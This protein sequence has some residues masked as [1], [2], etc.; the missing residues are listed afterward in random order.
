MSIGLSTIFCRNFSISKKSAILEI[1]CG[2]GYL[3][4]AVA[5]AGY[6]I[7]GLDISQEAVKNA[8][9][10]YGNHYLCADLAEYVQEHKKQFDVIIMT[11]LIEHTP[12]IKHFISIVNE[13]VK[14]D[15]HIVLTTPNKSAFAGDVVWQTELPPIHLWW[16]SK[17]SVRELAKQIGRKAIFT[18][19]SEFNKLNPLRPH[20]TLAGVPTVKT[21]FSADNKLLVIERIR[22][23]SW[24]SRNFKKIKIKFLGNF[25]KYTRVDRNIFCAV[26]TRP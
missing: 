3:T 4:Y 26:L 22:K 8:T 14:D 13:L 12:D 7:I 20:R 10:R 25:K 11:E 24:L 9:L 2:F 1:G 19:F 6:N 21:T 17:N 18:D 16:L 23:K 15:G 5:K